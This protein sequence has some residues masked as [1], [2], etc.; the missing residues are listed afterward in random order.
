MGIKKSKLSCKECR[1]WC[2]AFFFGETEDVIS[3]LI[4]V[5]ILT[6]PECCEYYKK[7]A[8]DCGFEWNI[9]DDLDLNKFAASFDEDTVQRIE[10]SI[11]DFEDTRQEEFVPD[12]W[13]QYTK[14][15]N[16]ENLI[17]MKAFKDLLLEYSSSIDNGDIDYTEYYKYITMKN[18]QKIDHLECCLRKEVQ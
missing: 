10:D 12:K 6:C 9:M 16:I 15:Y 13:Q 3:N 7:F 11:K 18:A 8:S 4:I 1:K 2:D 17:K 5:H 14:E